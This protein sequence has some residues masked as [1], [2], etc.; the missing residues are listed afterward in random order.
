[1]K[2]YFKIGLFLMAIIFVLASCNDKRRY[3]KDGFVYE[4]YGNILNY[5]GEEKIIS[6]PQK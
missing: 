2:R 1:M 4:I 3:T 5:E 6:I